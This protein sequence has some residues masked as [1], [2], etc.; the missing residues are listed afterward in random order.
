MKYFIYC[1]KHYADFSGRARRSEFWFYTLFNSIIS[2]VLA[3]GFFGKV[4]ALAYQESINPNDTM[5]VM[6]ALFTNPFL[7][8]LMLYSLA[9]FI[10]TLAVSVR[11]LHDIGRSGFW[12]LG[13]YV[14]SWIISIIMQ[15][16]TNN[17]IV[18][19]ILLF[20]MFAIAIWFLVWMFTDSQYGPNKYG[21][22]PK[23][24]GN[25]SEEETNNTEIDQ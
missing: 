25:P 4:V 10:P 15:I 22:N 17:P 9:V 1:L 11:R 21:D 24:M 2:L 13:Y 5:A 14:V 12:M 7:I 3:I 8:I 16:F 19:A 18:V 20:P 23:G 6:L